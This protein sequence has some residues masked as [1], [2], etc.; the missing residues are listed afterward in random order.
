MGLQRTGEV[1]SVVGYQAWSDVLRRNVGDAV[2]AAVER[3]IAAAVTG[4]AVLARVSAASCERKSVFINQSDNTI[5]L[6]LRQ[7]WVV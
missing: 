2:V 4:I 3:Q 1:G 5:S 7:W 6:Y